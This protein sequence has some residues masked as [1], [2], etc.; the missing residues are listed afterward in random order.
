MYKRRM[1]MFKKL[2]LALCVFMGTTTLAVAQDEGQPEKKGRQDVTIELEG[3]YWMPDFEGNM[4]VGLGQVQGTDVDIE[5]DLNLDLE[6]IPQGRVIWYT[7]PKSRL[8]LEYHNANFEGSKTITQPITFKGETFDA[9]AQLSSEID[10]DFYRL[11]WVWEF[12]ELGD[13]VFKFGTQLEA[14]YMDVST[15]LN[16]LIGGQAASRSRD[17]GLPLPLIGLALDINLI[18]DALNIFGSVT[19][20]PE[21]NGASYLSAEAGVKIIP[22]RNLSIGAGYRHEEARLEKDDDFVDI[23]ITGPFASLSLRF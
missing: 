4:Q 2:A 12:I 23:N 20:I 14:R 13:G 3:R 18:K 17:F 1:L 7:G 15:N 19:G 8:F 16:G 9:N 21:I 22:I 6:D 11:G 5:R 10:I